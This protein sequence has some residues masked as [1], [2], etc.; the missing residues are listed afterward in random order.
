M[1]RGGGDRQT[2]RQTDRRT[3]QDQTSPL[4]DAVGAMGKV[5]LSPC[6]RGFFRAAA[7]QKGGG[8]VRESRRMHKNLSG[9]GKVT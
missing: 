4:G 9:M 2:D 8:E 5:A 3:D 6:E 1:R 7:A